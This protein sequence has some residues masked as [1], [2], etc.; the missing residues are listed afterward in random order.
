MAKEFM[1]RGTVH[2]EVRLKLIGKTIYWH[3][4]IKILGHIWTAYITEWKN[5]PDTINLC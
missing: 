4:M 3:T 5:K 2:Q 1:C